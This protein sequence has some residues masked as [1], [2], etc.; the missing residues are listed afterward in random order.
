MGVVAGRSG[1]SIGA[2]LGDGGSFPP[3]TLQTQATGAKKS[4][5]PSAEPEDFFATQRV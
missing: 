4:R 5:N 3:H 1:E 2:A